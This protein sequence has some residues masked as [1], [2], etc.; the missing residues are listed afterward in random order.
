MRDTGRSF[1]GKLFASM[2][3]DLQTA[4][5]AAEEADR[6]QA[7]EHL[8]GTYEFAEFIAAVANAEAGAAL[9]PVAVEIVAGPSPRRALAIA[10]AADG[11]TLTSTDQAALAAYF[12]R[13]A[14]RLGGPR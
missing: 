3:Q 8:R 13:L 9:H 12:D 7:A 4:A 10:R 1:T 14:D 6:R 11:L 2:R 5:K